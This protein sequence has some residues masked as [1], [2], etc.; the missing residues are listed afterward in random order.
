MYVAKRAQAK[1]RAA[2]AGLNVNVFGR[3][4]GVR[5]RCTPV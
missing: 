5:L 4:V 1:A 3:R 2:D